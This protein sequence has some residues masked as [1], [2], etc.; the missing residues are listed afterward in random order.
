MLFSR[1]ITYAVAT[2]LFAGL[3]GCASSPDAKLYILSADA[4][5]QLANW[6]ENSPNV[7][8]RPISIAAHIKRPEIVYRTESNRVQ[9]N[10]YDRWAENIDK[11]M[12]AVLSE[13][14]M[15]LLGSGHIYTNDANFSTRP[16]MI[17]RVDVRQFGLT[18]GGQVSLDVSWEVEDSRSD[19]K[20]L[21]T[22]SFRSTPSSEQ[23]ADIVNAMSETIG[24]FSNA[25]SENLIQLQSIHNAEGAS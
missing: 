8:I 1:K 17:V 7:I 24:Q 25:L 19:T 13:N 22:E 4:T 15:Q 20:Q 2:V 12:A 3:A 11:G 18:A 10:E 5:T 14:L 6:G 23:V 16:D 21:R 9:V